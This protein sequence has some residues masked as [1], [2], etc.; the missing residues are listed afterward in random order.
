MPTRRI[1][2][3]QTNFATKQAMENA[4]QILE[5]LYIG[6]SLVAGNRQAL[7]NLGITAVLNCCE[8]I[9]FASRKTSNLLLRWTSLS[10]AA[11]VHCRAHKHMHVSSNEPARMISDR[12]VNAV[13][14][15]A[16]MFAYA[17]ASPVPFLQMN[18]DRGAEIL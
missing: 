1:S 16:M 6:G 5:W 14:A 9:P 4:D 12:P 13:H 17:F 8:R 3:T 10:F 7:S 11:S 2:K 15:A 18:S